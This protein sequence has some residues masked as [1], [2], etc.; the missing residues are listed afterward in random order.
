MGSWEDHDDAADEAEGEGEG[1]IGEI[2]GDEDGDEDIE[3]IDTRESE[4]EVQQ[5]SVNTNGFHTAGR[6]G[7]KERI[8]GI[9][10]KYDC[11]K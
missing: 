9:E 8:Q 6:E 10:M 1:E 11:S 4:N 5:S 3:D 2:E 7:M